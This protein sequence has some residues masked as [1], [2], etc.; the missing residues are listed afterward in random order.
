M[1][2]PEQV[3]LRFPRG[4]RDNERLILVR[5]RRGLEFRQLLRDEDGDWYVR[6]SLQI[7]ACEAGRI[8]AALAREIKHKRGCRVRGKASQVGFPG[9]TPGEQ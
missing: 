3:L 6:R 1:S 4:R 7:Y 9:M 5:T 8:A 2:A